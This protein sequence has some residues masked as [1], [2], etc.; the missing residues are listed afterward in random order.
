M[1]YAD[2][3]IYDGEFENNLASGYGTIRFVDGS[4]YNGFF[5]ENLYNGAGV[6]K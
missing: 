6:F 5:K 1:R 2:G 3:T 4:E